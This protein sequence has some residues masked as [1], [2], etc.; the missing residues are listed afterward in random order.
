MSAPTVARRWAVA[1]IALGSYAACADTTPPPQATPPT[2]TTTSVVPQPPDVTELDWEALAR[3]SKHTARASRG[4]TR[5]RNRVGGDLPPLHVV[6]CESGG[7]YT[8]E[9]PRSTA[10]GRYQIVDSSWNGY[11]GYSHAADAPPD[12]QDAKAR[13]MWNGGRGASHWSQC[14]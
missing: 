6:M 5:P 8:A 12:V 2:T 11:R 7:S 9:N 13:E 1:A 4:S 14:L 10:S 3:L